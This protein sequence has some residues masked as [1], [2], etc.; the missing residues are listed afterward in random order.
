MYFLCSILMS[1]S[2]GLTGLCSQSDHL[3]SL[4]H[5]FFGMILIFLVCVPC[6]CSTPPLSIL[7]AMIM[8]NVGELSVFYPVSLVAGVWLTHLCLSWG[9]CYTTLLVR[10]CTWLAWAE[11]VRQGP[12]CSSHPMRHSHIL[13]WQSTYTQDTALALV[14]LKSSQTVFW[15][16]KNVK[17]L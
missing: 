6:S 14:P 5:I 1:P 7:S 17:V 15:K 9:F 10:I 12:L 11:S 3:E 2:P 16:S 8:R 13:L 4:F